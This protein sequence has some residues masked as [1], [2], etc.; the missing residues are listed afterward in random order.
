VDLAG[1]VPVA[2]LLVDAELITAARL[3]IDIALAGL[4]KAEAAGEKVPIDELMRVARD[5]SELPS[6]M[7]HGR[8]SAL[9]DRFATLAGAVI[10]LPDGPPST[11][12]PARFLTALAIR[13]TVGEAE[14]SLATA[15]AALIRLLRGLAREPALRGV[16]PTSRLYRVLGRQPDGQFRVA[17][18]ADLLQ[19]LPSD[20]RWRPQS[21]LLPGA[22]V[23]A[24]AEGRASRHLRECA[25][26]L[27]R[28]LALSPFNSDSALIGQAAHVMEDLAFRH[29]DLDES[30][31]PRSDRTRRELLSLA[32]VLV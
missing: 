17:V 16:G 11:S 23:E 31:V 32:H 24:V 13:R 1:Q 21:A 29:S 20:Y 27:E 15:S 19:L 3:R 14:R 26:A 6:A 8:R 28:D 12:A 7:D 18:Y 2:D 5:V 30:V 25:L 4:T 10:R 22:L 9:V